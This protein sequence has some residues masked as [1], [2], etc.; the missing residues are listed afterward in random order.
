MPKFAFIAAG[1]DGSELKGVLEADTLTSARIALLNRDLDV[2][3][4]E[5]KRG[6]LQV[7]L[8]KTRIKRTELMHLSRQLAAFIRA[9]VPI[10]DAIQVLTE[11]S[12]SRGVQRVMAQIGEDLR[13]GST[14]SDAF[15]RHPD[16]FPDFYRGILRS[17]ELT[18]RLDTV[19]DQLSVYI[20]R[21]LEARRKITSAITYPALILGMSLATVVVL[22]TYVLPKFKVFFTSLDAELPLPTRI[23]MGSTSFI[24]STWYLLLGGLFLLALTVAIGVRTKPG[25]LLWHRTLLNVPV[26]G[27]TIRYAIVERYCRILSSMV[28]AGVSLTEA[29]TVARESIRNEVFDRGLRQAYEQ[30][31]QGGGL[32]RPLQATKLFPS[33]AS[34]MLRV[35]EETG[36]LDAQLE[37]AAAYFERELDYKIKRATSLLEPTVILFSGGFVGLV[38][39]AL[40][41]AMYGIFRTAHLS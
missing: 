1:A 2:T 41:S 39:I 7:E 16:D 33:T 19:L 23:L 4:I 31:L 15:E 13:A 24:A 37:M 21:D 35:G 30:M 20:E 5:E 29:M 36:S 9:G 27:E 11:E 17:A 8:T 6:A 22:A 32:A 34:Q 18:G 3:Q 10:L 26:L 28:S 25:R 12:S 38:A 40:V 14:L